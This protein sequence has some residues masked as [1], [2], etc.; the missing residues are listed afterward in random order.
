MVPVTPS[1][2]GSLVGAAL[3][4]HREGAGYD[5]DDAAEMLDCDRSRISRIETG[6]RGIPAEAL[7][8]LADGYGVPD[9]ERD[10]LLSIACE[11]RGD[12]G[13]W[14]DYKDVLPGTFLDYLIIEAAASGIVTFQAQQVPSLLQTGD[15]ARAAAA[16]GADVP[17]AWVPRIVESV[18]AR[19][20]AILATRPVP[21]DVTLTEAA[22]RQP[23]GPR[24]L[25]RAQLARMAHAAVND[26]H[27]TIRVIPFSAG[28]NAGIGLGSPT[29]LRF[30]AAPGYDVVHLPGL[31]GGALIT[32]PATVNAY[33]GAL[34]KV[35]ESALNPRES[36]LLIRAIS[37]E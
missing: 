29:L 20:Q 21:V 27:V 18:L 25:M 17:P 23:V 5:L 12:Y 8:R 1:S 30:D 6:E 7:L 33:S 34:A 16:A 13:A 24:R 36:Q 31:A 32:D 9:A 3:R 11:R 35:R 2:R 37:R 28:A 26:P 4:R 14:D 22:L 10:L 19:Q 15:Y